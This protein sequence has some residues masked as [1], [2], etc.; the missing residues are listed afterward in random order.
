MNSNLPCLVVPL[1]V[2]WTSRMAS[3]VHRNDDVELANRLRRGDE[4]ALE[5]LYERY[6]TLTF[7]L[8]LRIVGDR[9]LA[10]DIIQDCFLSVWRNAAGFDPSRS[11]L[12]S[13]LI[14]IIRNRCFD[15][16][17]SRASQPKIA[18]DVEISDQPGSHD[19]AEAV[20]TSLAAQR[21]REV[22]AELPPE[23]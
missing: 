15:R 14:T 6:G 22:L 7:T 4:S 2:S 5:L 11:S 16:L 18:P 23:Q 1:Y 8:A 17:R 10:E 20:V 9:Q 21:V 12:R 19:V 13:W 3:V